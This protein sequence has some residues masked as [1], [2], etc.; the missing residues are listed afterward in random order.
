MASMGVQFR[1]VR[2]QL[3]SRQQKTPPCQF[4]PRFPAYEGSEDAESRC[5]ESL[6]CFAP[7]L[8]EPMPGEMS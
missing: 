5:G 6:V 1:C 7:K 3:S 2:T 4:P 8:S